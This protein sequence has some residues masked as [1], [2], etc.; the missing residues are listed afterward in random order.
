VKPAVLL[1]LLLTLPLAACGGASSGVLPVPTTPDAGPSAFSVGGVDHPYFPIT[2]G[3]VRY[4]EGEDEGRLRWE[5]VRTL[6]AARDITGV[7]CTAVQQEVF[8][9][10]MLVE[11]TTEWYAQDRAGNVWK[12]GEK[13]F[14]LDPIDDS[15]MAGIDGAEPWIAFFADPQ[16]GDVYEGYRP[17]GRDAYEVTSVSETAE[18]PAG[19]Y[20]GCMQIVENAEDDEDD[21]EE[22]EPDD[23][24]IILYA[25]GVGRVQ[26]VNASGTIQLVAVERR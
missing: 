5:E 6:E 17:G 26:E 23:S 11:V 10:G 13:S 12:F 15:W 9:D 18:V 22:D 1:S 21:D 4:Y 3:T 24:D 19:T 8:L 14:D 25:R 7:P 20:T 2:P 16:V